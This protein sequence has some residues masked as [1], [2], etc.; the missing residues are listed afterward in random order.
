MSSPSTASEPLISTVLRRPDRQEIPIGALTDFEEALRDSNLPFLVE[1]HD[2]VRLPQRFHREIER[3]HVALLACGM[4][5][6]TR[7]KPMAAKDKVIRP[8]EEGIHQR[9]GQRPRPQ[10]PRPPANP[11]GQRPDDAKPTEGNASGKD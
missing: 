6:P 11:A 1:A 2:W 4:Q 3:R 10:T 8:L 7:R 9:G 5:Q